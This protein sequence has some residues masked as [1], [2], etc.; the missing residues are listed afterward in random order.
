M[1]DVVSERKAR[2]AE[3]A[4]AQGLLGGETL[5]AGFVDVAAVRAVVAEL[6]GAFPP[7]FTHAFAAKAGCL[8]GILA[9]VREAGMACEVASSGRAGAGGGRRLPRG[10]DR[11][12][13]ARQDPRRDPGRPRARHDGQ[14]RQ[15]PGAGACRCPDRRARRVARGDRHPDQPAGR[16]RDHRRHEHG[17]AHLEVRDRAR[18]PRQPRAHPGRL[19]RPPLAH[20]RAHPR[21]LAGLPARADRRRCRPRRWRWPAR[22]TR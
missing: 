22:S 16:G 5:L 10:A 11:V 12:R 19:S 7:H 9:L 2:V 6:R 4:V 1:D 20:L 18:R 21:R 17:D 15:F 8:E 14:H 13:F 3:A